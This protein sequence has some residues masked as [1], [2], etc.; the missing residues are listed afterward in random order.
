M[1][2]P[3]T[4]REIQ[5]VEYNG[6]TWVI[7]P[8]ISVTISKAGV[9]I[10]MTEVDADVDQLCG[11]KWAMQYPVEG[12]CST[13]CIKAMGHE[14]EHVDDRG[15]RRERVSSSDADRPPPPPRQC[16]FSWMH[17]H[18]RGRFPHRCI[19]HQGHDH[20]HSDVLGH[21]P[22][23]AEYNAAKACGAADY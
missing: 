18:A 15:N 14:G 19:R 12:L 17:K 16:G 5:F 9:V 10:A 7:P 22:T 6:A 23:L 3:N 20:V 13:T 8:G 21:T 4:G 1:R 11:M 2:I